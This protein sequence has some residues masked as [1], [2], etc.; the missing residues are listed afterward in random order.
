MNSLSKFIVSYVLVIG[1]AIL[2]FVQGILPIQ[3]LEPTGVWKDVD[4]DY[5]IAFK[6]DG[7]Y[8]ETDYNLAKQTVTTDNGMILYDITGKPNYVEFTRNYGGR[9]IVE[10]NGVTH[11]M[12]AS[13]DTPLLY[14]WESGITGVCVGAY[15]LKLDLDEQFYLK[16]YDTNQYEI[17]IGEERVIG[18]Y[19]YDDSLNLILL[20]SDGTTEV[21]YR[22]VEGYAFGSMNVNAEFLSDGVKENKLILGRVSDPTTG[23]VYSFT[24]DNTVIRL[25]GD[26]STE[27][28]YYVDDT[29]MITMT[30]SAGSG[31]TDYLWLNTS[32]KNI[33]R[34]LVINDEWYQFLSG[35]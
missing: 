1:L 24:N 8:V 4:S 10:L 33:Y 23:V 19:L 12:E 15:R 13:E 28:F 20:S 30:D 29:G 34:Y 32:T 9:A 31:V 3:T 18:K 2:V 27:F 7:T 14:D 35:T 11:V 26:I 25:N 6:V 17:T 22:C 21:L 5:Y 16:L